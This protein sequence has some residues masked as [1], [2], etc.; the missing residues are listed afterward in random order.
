MLVRLFFLQ[1]NIIELATTTRSCKASW[2]IL[3]LFGHHLVQFHVILLHFYLI[4]VSFTFRI[5]KYSKHS[6]F[7]IRNP[8][9]IANPIFIAK[10]SILVYWAHKWC[11]GSIL[12]FWCNKQSS[13][14]LWMMDANVQSE[15]QKFSQNAFVSRIDLL[16]SLHVPSVLF[17]RKCFQIYR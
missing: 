7:G 17:A 13:Q 1:D 6:Y 12:N 2:L 16:L 15:V 11:W 3:I 5:S 8:K 9:I 4:N 14:Y 10:S